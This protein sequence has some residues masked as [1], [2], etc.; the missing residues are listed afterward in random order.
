[1]NILKKII[2][3]IMSTVMALVIWI[4]FAQLGVAMFGPDSDAI[5]IVAVVGMLI[6]VWVGLSFF[7][8]MKKSKHD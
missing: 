1:M 7:D 5:I 3:A 6:G 2:V 8:Y 4:A